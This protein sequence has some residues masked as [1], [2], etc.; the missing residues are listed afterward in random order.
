[1]ETKTVTQLKQLSI[2]QLESY[3]NSISKE[4]AK[5]KKSSHAAG[6]IKAKRIAETPEAIAKAKINEGREEL[7]RLAEEAD[8]GSG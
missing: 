8:N 7:A 5:L 4:I 1:M 3:R 2:D 6:E